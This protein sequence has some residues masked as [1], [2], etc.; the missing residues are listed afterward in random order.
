MILQADNDTESSK[1]TLAIVITNFNM[2]TSNLAFSNLSCS[3]EPYMFKG[4]LKKAIYKQ[5]EWM[6]IHKKTYL[7]RTF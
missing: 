5:D 2:Q 4:G 1:V 7:E 6:K 3:T